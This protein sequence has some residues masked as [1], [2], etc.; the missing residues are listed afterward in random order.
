VLRETPIVDSRTSCSRS[1]FDGKILM[2]E[3]FEVKVDGL[4]VG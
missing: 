1:R 2:T 3:N 4:V